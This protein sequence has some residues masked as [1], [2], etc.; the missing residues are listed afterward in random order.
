[1]ELGSWFEVTTCHVIF[2]RLLR[3]SE[4][5]EPHSTCINHVFN[6]SALRIRWRRCFYCDC[7]VSVLGERD[8]FSSRAISLYPPLI[9]YYV[10]RERIFVRNNDGDSAASVTQVAAEAGRR[11]VQFS[12][13]ETCSMIVGFDLCLTTPLEISGSPSFLILKTSIIAAH[14]R[15]RHRSSKPM[16]RKIRPVVEWDLLPYTLILEC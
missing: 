15:G 13:A 1:M 2:V 7:L 10:R 5:F 3:Q 4:S 8:C 6:A 11:S 16:E 14:T 12:A 9:L